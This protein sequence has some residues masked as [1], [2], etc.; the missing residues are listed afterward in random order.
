[1]SKPLVFHAEPTRDELSSRFNSF[2]V[3]Q[4][5]E[6]N[7]DRPTGSSRAAYFSRQ[8]SQT[9]LLSAALPLEPWL[10]SALFT[11]SN[12]PAADLDDSR[13]DQLVARIRRLGKLKNLSD[14]LLLRILD[15][16]DFVPD[17]VGNGVVYSVSPNHFHES[18]GL[19]KCSRNRLAS[20]MCQ[21]NK[22]LRSF[23]RPQVPCWVSISS[24]GISSLCFGR[25]DEAVALL[26][27]QVFR[28]G[29]PTAYWYLLLS[30]E[31]ELYLPH[32]QVD[33]RL[34]SLVAGSLFGELYIPRHTCAARVTRPA[35]FVRILQSHFAA[36][37]NK[38]ADHLQP[39][40]TVMEDLTSEMTSRKCRPG[41]QN[42]SQL[43]IDCGSRD[44]N[45]VFRGTRPFRR[46]RRH[47]RSAKTC[48]RVPQA[49]FPA[50][51]QVA[52]H[53]HSEMHSFP[54]GP[55]AG[56]H[57][58]REAFV[59]F[60]A[61]GKGLIRSTG[62][63]CVPP[64]ALWNLVAPERKFQGHHEKRDRETLELVAKYET[65][66]HKIPLVV[67][68]ILGWSCSL[69]TFISD[70][71]SPIYGVLDLLNVKLL[72]CGL[73]NGSLNGTMTTLGPGANPHKFS[74]NF[75]AR[76]T[77]AHTLL[78][79]F[80]CQT[81]TISSKCAR[82]VGG[83]LSPM[84]MFMKYELFIFPVFTVSGLLHG[85]CRLALNDGKVA[86]SKDALRSVISHL[87]PLI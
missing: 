69:L 43:V 24:F 7:Y 80:F 60:R 46:D 1:M 23:G 47:S 87:L 31:V 82:R 49:P 70:T 45:N 57:A 35:E 84:L 18:N 30:G 61:A 44:K 5:S 58:R 9:Q 76:F 40:I 77:G 26:Q 52:T 21:K 4:S 10:I 32:P 13:M 67:L 85:G 37:Y 78:D 51:I 86:S 66:L 2:F 12:Q 75:R 41:L 33:C 19:I 15:S 3:T 53:G 22:H 11:A 63:T 55:H 54:P 59:V 29:D 16:S 56:F 34:Q 64:R 8:R 50:H 42:K 71:Q 39:F 73:P 27:G 48:V 81:M 20:C 14:A 38:H 65:A 17:R 79:S 28:P 74:S 62:C 72:P 36:V 25:L 6:H 83:S 68:F